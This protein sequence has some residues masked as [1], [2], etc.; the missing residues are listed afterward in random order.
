MD[1][2]IEL[3][4]L[5][6]ARK[7]NATN[8]FGIVLGEKNGLRKISILIGSEE[9]RAIAI[10]LEKIQIGRPLP[11]DLIVTMLTQFNVYVTEVYVHTLT[12]GI[13]YCSV[14][15]KT[16][17]S[18]EPFLFDTRISDAIAIA[19]RTKAPIYIAADILEQKNKGATTPPTEKAVEKESETKKE[20]SDYE[21]FTTDKIKFISTETL[22]KKLGELLEKEDYLLAAL[23]RDELKM[24]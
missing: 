24:R 10:I 17:Q 18:Q 15:T 13:Y 6:L 16:K 21:V 7:A 1:E 3:E 12:D 5:A 11:H 4:I 23:V 8:S 19:L 14:I 9:A 2:K 22:H 20:T